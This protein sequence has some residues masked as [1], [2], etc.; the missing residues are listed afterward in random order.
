MVIA[1]QLYIG[2]K[3]NTYTDMNSIAV[4]IWQRMRQLR[5]RIQQRVG[6]FFSIFFIV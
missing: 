1:L 2:P 3:H 6:I 4:H 5:M